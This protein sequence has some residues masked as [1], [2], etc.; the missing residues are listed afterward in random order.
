MAVITVRHT[1]P[2]I[3][4]VRYGVYQTFVAPGVTVGHA[5]HQLRQPWAIPSGAVAV[6]HDATAARLVDESYRIQPGDLIIF[7]RSVK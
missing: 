2:G 4:S 1:K 7:D 3:A 6:C 5:F